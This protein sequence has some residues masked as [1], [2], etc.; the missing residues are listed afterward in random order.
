IDAHYAANAVGATCTARPEDTKIAKDGSLFIAFTSGS[1]SKTDGSPNL[2]IFKGKDGKTY[3]YGW[4]MRLIENGNEPGAMAFQ[5]KMFATG[6]E[7][8]EGGLGFANPDNIAFD[9]G[10]NLWI[11]TDMSS[12]KQNKAVPQGR[13][14][15]E[16]KPIGQ[17]DLRGLFGNNSI[18]F[19]PTSGQNAGEAYLFGYG[20][21]DCETTGPFFTRDQQTLFLAI[22]HPGEINGTRK[23]MES[24]DREFAIGT[25]DGKE[26]IQT[27][28]IPIGSNWPGKG[29]N[30]PPKPAVVAIRKI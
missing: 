30:D 15:R 14:D 23:D 17:S 22:Q 13:L 6:G 16:G 27:R 20:P 12:D 26:F 1:I 18:W 3:E 4:I 21:M 7:P 24:K 5:C 9:S 29:P 19:M 11:V 2:R 25:T 10:G 28:T 8:A